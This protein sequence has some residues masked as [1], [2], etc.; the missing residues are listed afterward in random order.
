MWLPTGTTFK[1][2]FVFLLMKEISGF[3]YDDNPD[4]VNLTPSNFN[5]EVIASDDV[6]IVEFYAKWCPH[7]Q[8]FAPNWIDLASRMKGIAKIGAVDAPKYRS[9][10]QKYG[11]MR[12]PTILIFGADKENYKTYHG[13]R[14]VKEMEAYFRNL[15]SKEKS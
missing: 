7:C 5:S 15:V 8:K 4:I 13:S 11:V 1:A 2:L 12:T 10:G 6:W 9:L 3:S 14:S